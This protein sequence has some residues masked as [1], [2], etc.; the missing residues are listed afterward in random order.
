MGTMDQQFEKPAP[1]NEII[2]FLYKDLLTFNNFDAVSEILD[3]K[4][5]KAEDIK[6]FLDQTPFSDLEKISAKI[7][8]YRNAHK[9]ETE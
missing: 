3:T 7:E 1:K 4:M 6:N 5:E 8:R 2:D 9:I